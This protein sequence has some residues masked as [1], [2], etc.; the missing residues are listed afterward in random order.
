VALSLDLAAP[1]VATQGQADPQIAVP[2]TPS[3]RVGCGTRVGCGPLSNRR[4]GCR[5]GGPAEC[6]APFADPIHT[7]SARTFPEQD[8][9][10]RS[11]LSYFLTGVSAGAIA[12]AAGSLLSP[13]PLSPRLLSSSGVNS[14]SMSKFP[15][16]DGSVSATVDGAAASL[17][18]V[19]AV[20]VSAAG[21][22]AAETSAVDAL[23]FCW[24]AATVKLA[25][26][27]VPTTRF[28][29]KVTASSGYWALF[30]CP[31]PSFVDSSSPNG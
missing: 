31:P 15:A 27:I 16:N 21:V 25:T 30:I 13:G 2:L 4:A 23:S 26:M 17:A 14:G 28:L 18:E 19:S 11:E 3:P 5:S 24:Q 20:V 12:S 9:W 29:I 8:V 1:H 7:R 22:S 10:L 6:A